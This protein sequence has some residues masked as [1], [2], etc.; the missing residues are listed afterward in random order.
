MMLAT[1]IPAIYQFSW[2]W[3]CFIPLIAIALGIWTGWKKNKDQ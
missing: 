2:G 1:D 3:W